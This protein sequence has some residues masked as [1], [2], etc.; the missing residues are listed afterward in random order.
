MRDA[1][2]KAGFT[3]ISTLAAS[4]THSA[5]AS[6]NSAYIN[7]ITL[8]SAANS[9]EVTPGGLHPNARGVAFLVRSVVPEIKSAF[10]RQAMTSTPQPSSAPESPVLRWT[11]GVVSLLALLTV[12]ALVMVRLRRRTHDEP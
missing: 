5:C 7:G 9:T 6:L 11:I 8:R 4:A 1:A 3:Y 10:A 2:Q 12:A